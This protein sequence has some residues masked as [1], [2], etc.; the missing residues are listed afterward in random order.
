[1]LP[2][3]Q[4]NPGRLLVKSRRS[5]SCSVNI[6]S[7]RLFCRLGGWRHKQ[8]KCSVLRCKVIDACTTSCSV[9]CCIVIDACTT[10]NDVWVSLKF[11]LNVMLEP[12]TDL[13]IVEIPPPRNRDWHEND[14]TS[15]PLGAN[16]TV[17]VSSPWTLSHVSVKEKKL[18]PLSFK[19]VDILHRL[20]TI[21]LS[22]TDCA[23][24]ET[25]MNGCTFCF[26]LFTPRLERWRRGW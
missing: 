16:S 22:I 23:S 7:I 10:S 13:F 8:K 17:L 26:F 11:V 19:N 21:S 15:N 9:L 18:T 20:Q 2:T 12:K 6:E 1:M 5:S 25:T 14:F 4:T 3:R 24:N